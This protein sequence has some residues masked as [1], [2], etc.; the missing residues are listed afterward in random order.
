MAEIADLTGAEF[1]KS[2]YSTNGN[3]IVAAGTVSDGAGTFDTLA[4]DDG[5]RQ[6]RIVTGSFADAPAQHVQDP[7]GHVL[8]LP[9]Y[10][11]PV[12]RLPGREVRRQLPP[13]VTGPHHVHDRVH[14]VSERILLL[15]AVPVGSGNQQL[16]Q[17]PLLIGQIRGVKRV[18]V[19]SL[20]SYPTAR[21]PHDHL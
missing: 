14:D 17:S 15:A 20:P 8:V 10:K 3:D 12:H 4:V 19:S 16:D 21:R 18:V 9:A 11:M 13:G 2:S 5:R 1:R 6:L 7:L